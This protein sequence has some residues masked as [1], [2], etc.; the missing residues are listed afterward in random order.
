MM[1]ASRIRCGLASQRG[2]PP[3]VRER[4]LQQKAARIAASP[5]PAD[6]AVD[7]SVSERACQAETV[8]FWMAPQR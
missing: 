8:S 2:K 4:A 7:V 5:V 6:T 3:S 1:A